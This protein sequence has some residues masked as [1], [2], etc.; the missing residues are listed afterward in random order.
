ML[1]VQFNQSP[2]DCSQFFA[3]MKKHYEKYPRICSHVS[4]TL[5]SIPWKFIMF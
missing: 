5:E 1:Y 4:I 3:F 2:I